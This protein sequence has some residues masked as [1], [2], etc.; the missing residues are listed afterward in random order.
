MIKRAA[1]I[2]FEDWVTDEEAREAIESIANVIKAPVEY[3]Y[4]KQVGIKKPVG[5]Y[6]EEYD[7]EFGGPVWYIP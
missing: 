6:V 5:E 7:D 4:K 3:D 1:L 2:Y